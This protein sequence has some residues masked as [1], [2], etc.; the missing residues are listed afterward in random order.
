MNAGVLSLPNAKSEELYYSRITAIVY[1]QRRALSN[2]QWAWQPNVAD[3]MVKSAHFVFK[4]N[5]RRSSRR[6]AFFA[7]YTVIRPA[8]V[9]TAQAGTPLKKLRFS[10]LFFLSFSLDCAHPRSPEEEG[11]HRTDVKTEPV[12]LKDLTGKT[13]VRDAAFQETP[14]AAAR[15]CPS[16]AVEEDKRNM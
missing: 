1:L 9:G 11:K 12:S 14:I 3:F 6:S 15:K 4:D 16:R 5:V 7:P 13:A 8:Q 2:L 10:S